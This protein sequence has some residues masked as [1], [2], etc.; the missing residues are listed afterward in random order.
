MKKTFN[1]DRRDEQ[2]RVIQEVLELP[3]VQE[4]LASGWKIERETLP[5]GDVQIC[6]ISA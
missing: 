6:L 5:N 3:E 4:L 2:E 1:K